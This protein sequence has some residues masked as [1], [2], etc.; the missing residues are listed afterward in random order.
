MDN[1]WRRARLIPVRGIGSEKE[2]EERAT[3][4]LLAV[5]S[6][7][8]PLSAELF[9]PMG[10]SGA[11]RAT[12]EC[13]T[14]VIFDLDGKKVRPDGLVRVSY[15]KGTWT[16]LI[17]VKTG[18]SRLD[19]DQLTSYIKMARARKFDCVI[20]ISNEIAPAPGH[21]PTPAAVPRANSTVQLHHISWTQLVTTAVRLHEHIGVDDAEQRWLLGELIRYLQH[22]ASGAL[23]FNDMGGDWVAVRN[24]AKDG[25]LSKGEAGAMDIAQ[26]WDQLVRYIALMMGA[27]TGLDVVQ[28]LSRSHASDPRARADA[29]VKQLADAGRLD[30]TLR[31][32]NTTG[33]LEVCVDLRSRQVV[34]ST[35]IKA[36]EDK[37]ARGRVGWLTRQLRDAAPGDLQIESRA[38][39]AKIG[40][41]ASLAAAVEDSALL[42]DDQKRDPATF[43][44]TSRSDMGAGRIVGKGKGA[45]FIESVEDA[46]NAFYDQVLSRLSAWQPKAAPRQTVAEP[47]DEQTFEDG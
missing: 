4:A 14:E 24:A 20:T 43:T 17:E 25:T 2:A 29:V 13:F 32:P 9:K 35:T 16:A 23:S 46:I 31:I 10:A 19:P 15:G 37:G 39:R 47:A 21:H 40:P 5:L 30:A 41:T 6:I 11:A 8:R 26:R 45:S 7:V 12:V 27:Q 36:P 1:N 42:V 3:S 34:C 28:Y 22:S 33:D 38:H 44:L 18:T